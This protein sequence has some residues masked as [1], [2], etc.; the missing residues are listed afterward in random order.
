[1][2][3]SV[4]SGAML[5]HGYGYHHC[6]FPGAGVMVR[7]PAPAQPEALTTLTI[8]DYAGITRGRS[9]TR[10]SFD[11]SKGPKTCGWVPANMFAHELRHH[12]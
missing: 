11:K 6:A 9:V 3:R 5:D 7:R 2:R 4:P 1:M 10:T 12:C 8:I